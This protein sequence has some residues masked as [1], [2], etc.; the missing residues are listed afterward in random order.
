MEKFEETVFE[1]ENETFW[2]SLGRFGVWRLRME[3]CIEVKGIR[4]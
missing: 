1:L 3:G 4:D 2:L